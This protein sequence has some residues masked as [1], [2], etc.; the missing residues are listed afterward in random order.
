[1]VGKTGGGGKKLLEG[2]PLG[3]FA[4]L[5]AA[6]VSAGVEILIEKRADVE[7][8]ERIRFG[9]VRNFFG[10]SLEEGF[11]AVVI[12]LRRLFALLFQDGIG[13]HLLVDHLAQLKPVERE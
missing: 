3:N 1:M 13:N 9:L 8:V 4:L 12:G 11:V 7:F 10:F 6:A 2:G 5:R